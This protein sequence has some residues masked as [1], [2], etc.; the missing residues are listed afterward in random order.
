MTPTPPSTP[1]PPPDPWMRHSYIEKGGL[2]GGATVSMNQREQE[3]ARERPWYRR[4]WGIPSQ[5][6]VDSWEL[7]RP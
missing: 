1:L 5:A 7:K 6:E 2:S 4:L 3:R